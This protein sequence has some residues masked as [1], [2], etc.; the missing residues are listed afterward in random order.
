MKMSFFPAIAGI[1]AAILALPLASSSIAQ[2][3]PGVTEHEIVIGSCS[4][5]EGPSHFLGTQTVTGASAYFDLINSEGGIHGRKL[6]LIAYDDS[7]DPAKT[8]ECF[9]R[10]EKQEVF[11]MG[12]FV[13]T[14]TAV[15]YVPL[16]DSA[17][18]PLIGLFTGAQT[19]YAPLRHWVINVR[20]SY[21][22]ETREQVNGLWDTLGFRKIAVIYPD[23][24]FG[25]A[26]LNGV[27]DALR[28]KGADVS[29][30]GSYVRQT[31]HA[32]DA[33][34]KVRAANPQAVVIVG[35]SNTVGPIVKQAHAKG[36]HPLFLTVSFVGTDDL[37]LQ[38]GDD[39]EGMV[40]TQVVPPYYLT[41]LK[42]VAL[43]R[44]TLSKFFPSEQ[45][46][47]VSLEGFVDAMVMVEGLKRSGNDLTREGLIRAIESIH[48][49]DLGLGPKLELN[50]SAKSHKGLDHVIPTVIR[51][52]RAV[53]FTD[54]SMV[55]PK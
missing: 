11:A 18:I 20:A 29:A 10:L 6:R 24:A 25:G 41:E 17:R 15:K 14:P 47:F 31:T 37:I 8:E 42:T 26:V 35:P 44:R 34:E 4:A 30:E 50:Y 54:W 22:D 33:I 16:A 53:P 3:T 19:L 7:Y 52:G 13:G 40:V 2:T 48:N 23:D 5:L 21:E 46:N 45:P 38:A 51:G 55:A 43:Y 32:D 28:A 1:A 39:V 9:H 12:F 27:K 36:W 49:M